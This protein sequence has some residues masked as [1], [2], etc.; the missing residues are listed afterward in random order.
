KFLLQG[1]AFN[2]NSVNP[3]AWAAVLR[4][5]RFPAPNPFKYLDVDSATGTAADDATQSLTS[6]DASFLRFSQSAQE[7]YKA[8]D[9]YIQSGSATDVVNTPLFRRGVRTLTTDQVSTLA[10]KITDA[11]K[12]HLTAN[13]PFHSLQEFLSPTA[14]GSPSL[15]EQAIIDAG[16]NSS[17]S[18]F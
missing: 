7:V 17:I 16:I 6:I 1:G 12:A 9:G 5:V 4:G 14:A 3:A 10:T 15:L 2:L 8:D 13:G 18:E 11:I